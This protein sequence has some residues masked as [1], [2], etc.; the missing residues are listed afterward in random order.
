MHGCDIMARK[1][2]I[3]GNCG[4]FYAGHCISKEISVDALQTVCKTHFRYW[5]SYEYKNNKEDV[6][7][8]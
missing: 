1:N 6:K 8:L 2:K 7:C 4:G 5:T 3:C